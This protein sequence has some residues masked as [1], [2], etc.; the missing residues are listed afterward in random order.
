[1][2]EFRFQMRNESDGNDGEICEALRHDFGHWSIEVR[3]GVLAY[4]PKHKYSKNV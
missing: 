1:M 3:L 2:V 4:Q